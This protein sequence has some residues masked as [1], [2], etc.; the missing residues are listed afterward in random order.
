MR[1]AIRRPEF[2]RLFAI[3]NNSYFQKQYL[4]KGDFLEYSEGVGVNDGRRPTA[5][6]PRAWR[7]GGK[8]NRPAKL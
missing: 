2:Q 5:R 6:K 7:A 1:G 4:D 8:L 3:P